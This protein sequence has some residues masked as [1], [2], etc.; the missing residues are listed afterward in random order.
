MK[1]IVK[2]LIAA[3]LTLLSVSLIAQE[4]TVTAGVEIYGSGGTASISIGQVFFTSFT[5]ETYEINQGV[6]QPYI[7]TEVTSAGNTSVTNL[8]LKVF[9]NPT[10][11]FINI[12]IDKTEKVHMSFYLFDA[13]GRVLQNGE[14]KAAETEIAMGHLSSAIYFLRIIEE[15]NE[16]KT[17]KII[18]N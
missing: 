16:V 3:I 14:I 2:C 1:I 8:E 12:R 6:Q 4:T 13:A 17:F 11:D 15:D 9:P 5:G 7:I 10:T 18:K